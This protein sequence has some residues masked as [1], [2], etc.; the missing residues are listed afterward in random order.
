M[1]E[2]RKRTV[3]RTGLYTGIAF[4]VT[5][6]TSCRKAAPADQRPAMRERHVVH[7]QWD[8]SFVVGSSAA[9]SSLLMPIRP[10]AG[11]DGVFLAD[12]YGN[13]IV[14]YDQ[15][16]KRLWTFGKKGAG[17][18]EF[19]RI[20]DVKVDNAGRVWVL[21]Q[22]NLRLTIVS[23]SGQPE[24]RISLA[25][26]GQMPQ[27]VIPLASGNAV[28]LT[29]DANT[30]LAQVDRE[31]RL[32]GRTAFPWAGF[33]TLN[34]MVTQFATAFEPATGRWIAAF[35]MGNG[36]YTFHDT[37]SLGYAGRYI[38]SV[39]FPE[40]EEIRSGNSV[41]TRL[42][43]RPILAAKSVSLSPTTVYVLFQG[44]GPYAR[45]IVDTY[46]V[47]DGRYVSSILLPRLVDEIAWSDKGLYVT[48]SDPYPH[49]AL[50]RTRSAQ[51]P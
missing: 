39:P 22:G 10:T 45:R 32:V 25:Q 21:D 23:A 17:P 27:G 16:G 19:Q 12:F 5:L 44:T 34:P 29:Y 20:R 35:Q 15:H 1:T 26:L 8:T 49:L 47:E 2:P 9:D 18:D 43:G 36:F 13:R 40:V 48:Y 11:R 46:S 33:R 38:E 6:V 4:V 42:K 24:K 31:G 41:D 14:H 30:P 28:V 50:W 37:A 3:V 7:T 51:L